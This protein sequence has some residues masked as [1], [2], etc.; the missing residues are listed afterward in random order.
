ILEYAETADGGIRRFWQPPQILPIRPFSIIAGA[1][2]GHSNAVPETYLLFNGTSDGVFDGIPV[3]D[4]LPINAKAVLAYRTFGKRENLKNHD[5]YYVEGNISASTNDLG[6]TLRYDFGGFTQEILKEIDG[7]DNTILLES[8]DATSLGQQPLG[9]QPLGG[10]VQEPPSLA[11]FRVYFEIPKEDYHE[12]QEIF[13]SNGVDQIWEVL[14]TG[15]NV[16][17]S[18]RRN[19]TNRL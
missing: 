12:L 9:T 11:R 13:E 16:K 1:L 3:A 6:F 19:T 18:R 14:A 7:T 4:K 2:Y 10:S 17:F 15:G 5:E 8:L